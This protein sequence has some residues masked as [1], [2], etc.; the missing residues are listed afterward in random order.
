MLC[1]RQAQNIYGLRP[2]I[3]FPVKSCF[4]ST[5]APRSSEVSP[6]RAGLVSPRAARLSSEV[7]FGWELSI[8]VASPNPLDDFELLWLNYRKPLSLG[9]DTTEDILLLVRAGGLQCDAPLLR[10]RV[11]AL[12]SLDQQVQ[13]LDAARLIKTDPLV[14]AHS[15]R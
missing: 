10:S 14:L 3:L 2:R 4:L 7:P 6:S 9:K 12:R 1:T 5:N 11:V 13:G 8:S 15:P